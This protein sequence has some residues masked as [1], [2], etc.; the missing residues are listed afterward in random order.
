VITVVRSDSASSAALVRVPYRGPFRSFLLNANR[1]HDLLGSVGDKDSPLGTAKDRPKLDRSASGPGRDTEEPVDEQRDGDLGGAVVHAPDAGPGLGQV[2]VYLDEVALA[3]G[4]RDGDL[5]E[6]AMCQGVAPGPPSEI[7]GQPWRSSS[8]IQRKS[9]TTRTTWGWDSSRTKTNGPFAWMA[10]TLMGRKG[11][12]PAQM[13]T[14]N[15]FSL[16]RDDAVVLGQR[17]AR[18]VIGSTLGRTSFPW[19]LRFRS[20]KAQELRVSCLTRLRRQNEQSSQIP[21]KSGLRACRV[22][23]AR[24]GQVAPLYGESALLNQR[25]HSSVGFCPAAIARPT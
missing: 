5:S 20:R 14:R 16:A 10:H 17:V 22:L 12:F 1:H 11:S 7:V 24:R 13:T 3:D 15:R 19:P 6:P 2:G 25:S 4:Q 8:W 23:R 9:A 18:V 21:G